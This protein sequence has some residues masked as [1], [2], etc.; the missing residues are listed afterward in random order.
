PE[1]ALVRHSE[2]AASRS[3]QYVLDAFAVARCSET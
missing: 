1:F 3:K 2:L